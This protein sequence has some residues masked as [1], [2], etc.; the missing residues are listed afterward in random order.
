M[1]VGGILRHPIDA[2]R[3]LGL[4]LGCPFRL[5]IPVSAAAGIVVLAATG[6]ICIGT[7]SSSSRAQPWSAALFSILLFLFL[8]SVSLAAGRLTPAFLHLDTRDPLPSKYFTLICE[9]WAAIAMLVLYACWSQ[10]V[11]VGFL[12]FYG[13]LFGCLMFAT[14]RRQLV[15]ASDWADVFLGA[16]AVGSAFLLDAPDEQLLSVLGP[17]KANRE[18]RVAFLKQH[19]LAM[20]HDPRAQWPGRLVS[21]LFPPPA[22][23][24]IG[25]IEKTVRLSGSSWRVTGWAWDIDTASSPDDILFAGADGRIVGMARGGLRHGYMPG[26]LFEPGAVPASHAQFRDSEWLGYVRQEGGVAWAEIR[27]YGVLRSKRGACEV[28]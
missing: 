16:D 20:F 6:Y 3:I 4:I 19:R 12:C 26:F 5:S 10:R 18:E 1:G 14:L 9:S 24:C 13:V 21:N 27:L 25:A 22:G 7:F 11:R 17:T 15:E 28:R 23:R 8:S 2:I